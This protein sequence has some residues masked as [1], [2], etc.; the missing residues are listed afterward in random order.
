MDPIAITI[1]ISWTV[2]GLLCIALAIPLVRGHVG[3]N[4]F[5]GV[6]FPQSFQSDDAWVAINRFGGKRLVVWSIPLM[7][8]GLVAFFLPLQS[9]TSLTL[10]FG[11]APLIFVL[12]PVFEAW[13][14]AKQYPSKS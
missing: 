5:Y 2:V 1:G 10:L 12:M 11:F 6:R 14:F 7:L 4:A 13:R 9:N 3:R 8:I